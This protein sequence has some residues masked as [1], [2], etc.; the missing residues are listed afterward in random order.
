MLLCP[1]LE[2]G[3]RVAVSPEGT[4]DDI[5]S[6]VHEIWHNWLILRTVPRNIS[7]LSEPVSIAG[8]V[9]LMEDWGLSSSPLSVSVWNR[10]VLWQD[11]AEVP[12]EEIWVVGESSRVESVVPHDNW[13]LE[14]KTSSESLGDEEHE[15]GVRQPASNVEILD[16]EFSNNCETKKASQLSSSGI[17]GPI[18]VGFLNWSDDNLIGLVLW[19]PGGEDINVFLGLWSP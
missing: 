2:C 14:S 6:S 5:G 7:W 11:S 13:S 17:V 3:S 18:P 1:S 15:V 12:P 9:V 10:W 8:L 19:E 16:W 4:V